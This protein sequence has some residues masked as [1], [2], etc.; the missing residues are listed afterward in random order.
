VK[1]AK[2]KAKRAAKKCT[3]KKPKQKKK[4]GSTGRPKPVVRM[5]ATE[6]KA[7]RP[8]EPEAEAPKDFVEVRKNIASLVRNSAGKIAAKAIEVAM[9]GQLAPAK[10]FFEA[11]GLYPPTAETSGPEES[12]AY[13]LLM[14]PARP[15]EESD[16]EDGGVSDGEVELVGEKKLDGLGGEDEASPNEEVVEQRSTQ[17]AGADLSTGLSSD[18]SSRLSTGRSD[19]SGE[20]MP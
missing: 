9:G 13:E 17:P 3:A 10:Y 1:K 8:E 18:L 5:R 7:A 20:G 14:R 11:V 12:L 15:I 4:A 19:T 2:G 6:G 16:G